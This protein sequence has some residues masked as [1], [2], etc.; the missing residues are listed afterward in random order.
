MSSLILRTSLV[1][2]ESKHRKLSAK[3]MVG[4]KTDLVDAAGSMG[5]ETVALWCAHVLLQVIIMILLAKITW[6]VQ[7]RIHMCI[8]VEY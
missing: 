3:V 2:I 6:V 8:T 7:F 1:I 4:I 5:M